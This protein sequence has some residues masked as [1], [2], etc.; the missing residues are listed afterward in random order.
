MRQELENFRAK[1]ELNMATNPGVV[2]QFEK[3]QRQVG[4]QSLDD[5]DAVQY[6]DFSSQI[7]GLRKALEDKEAKRANCDKKLRKTRVCP[8]LSRCALFLTCRH[9]TNG[10]QHCAPLSKKSTR[11]SL[12]P[13]SV[14][15]TS[16]SVSDISQTPYV[17]V[18][19]AGEIKIGEADDD[20]DN[21]TIDIMVK[22]RDTEKMQLL[23]G[24]RQS[25]GVCVFL[26]GY[27]SLI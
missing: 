17:G 3:R 14:S 2:E 16:T 24:Q 7:E 19:C 22:F 26:V 23:T 13:L 21:W 20:Y 8:S 4:L 9:R 18:H 1:L 27:V 10:T 12:T 6:P 15:W 25:G 11:S 5:Y